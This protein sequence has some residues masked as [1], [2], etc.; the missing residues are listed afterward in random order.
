MRLPFL[1]AGPALPREI[2]PAPR[3]AFYQSQEMT[4]TWRATP[5]TG[6]AA[7]AQ[8]QDLTMRSRPGAVLRQDQIFLMRGRPRAAFLQEQSF[9]ATSSVG[10]G[11]WPNGYLNQHEIRLRAWPGGGTPVANFLLPFAEQSDAFKTVANGGGVEHA[12]GYDIRFE[13][14]GGTKLGHI[15]ISYDGTTGRVRALVNMPRN[16]AA[17][18]SIFLY[19]G[20][21]GLVASEESAANARA[22]GWLAWF[23]GGSVTDLTGQGR[24]L[25][26]TGTPGATTLLGWPAYDFDGIDD[27]GGGLAAAGFLNGLPAVSAVMLGQADAINQLRGFFAVPN[28]TQTEIGLRFKDSNGRMVVALKFGTSVVICESADGAQTTG[29]FAAAFTGQA[30]SPI[31]LAI[32]GKATTPSVPG[33]SLSGSL[34]VTGNLEWGRGGVGSIGFWN[35]PG[36]FLAL[37]AGAMSAAELESMT[38]ALVDPRKVYGV[39][40]A[41]LVTVPNRGPTA[42]PVFTTAEAGVAKDVSVVADAYD[43]NGDPMTATD[44]TVVTGAATATVPSLTG[45]NV[46]FTGNSGLEQ[47]LILDFGIKDGGGKRSR[48]R[49]YATVA[50]LIITGYPKWPMGY[51]SWTSVPVARIRPVGFG[52]SGAPGPSGGYPTIAAA[53][54]AAVASDWIVV[55]DGTWAGNLTFGRDFADPGVVICGRNIAT[56][57]RDPLTILTGKYTVS[58]DG[59]WFHHLRISYAGTT[60]DDVQSTSSFEGHPFVVS[61]AR[62]TWTRN[63][64]TIP[65]GIQLTWGDG[66]HTNR[67]CYNRWTTTRPHGNSWISMANGHTNPSKNRLH[68]TLIARNY[69]RQHTTATYKNS[70]L[71]HIGNAHAD[72]GDFW[73]SPNFRIEENLV[74]CADSIG[75]DKFVYLKFGIQSF[76]RNTLI[77]DASYIHRHGSILYT[78][79]ASAKTESTITCPEWHGNW[80]EGLSGGYAGPVKFNATGFDIRGN[81]IKSSQGIHLFNGYN[82]SSGAPYQAA[83][84]SLLVGNQVIT[85]GSPPNKPYTI[86]RVDSD[87]S[88]YNQTQ[89][90]KIRNV[91]IWG[92]HPSGTAVTG[93]VS[94]L[95]YAAAEVEGATCSFSTSLGS[96]PTPPAPVK[97][98]ES[99]VGF[100]TTG[101]GV[102]AA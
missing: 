4:A 86:G 10:A 102:P 84:D 55:N 12:S 72:A 81:Y 46:R 25:T 78:T 88:A 85:S 3:A 75:Y 48:G 58:G 59:H 99:D 38:A 22:G 63:W 9:T 91:N 70:Y 31:S 53:Y 19:V 76:S 79:P 62:N 33:G 93:G 18:E 54:A 68:D 27:Y 43:P 50:A 20:K 45:G 44:V 67:I 65:K 41:N 8:D 2:V 11:R 73:F 94:S 61:G 71:I 95:F 36:A 100:Q 89:G 1:S 66:T 56:N 60:T 37:R 14:A 29:P 23:K 35:G 17:A 32:N 64:F 42:L 97:L 6:S 57:G 26:A 16:F 96:Y 82:D 90:H 52:V 92:H 101:Q 5:S 40:A 47:E 74:I 7:F 30:G 21:P 80:I 28:A 83:S 98:G 13:T 87:F 15:L 49:L 39:G 77:G 69:M 51:T 24:N 34:S